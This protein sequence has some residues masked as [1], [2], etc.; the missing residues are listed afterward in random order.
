MSQQ[1]LKKELLPRH[2][3]MMALGGMIGTGIFKGSADTIS[4][5]GPGIVI[6][7]LLGG[8]LLYFVMG[9]LAEMASAYPN[10][11]IRALLHKAFGA[12]ASFVIG[13]LYWIQWILVMSVEVVAAGLFLQF[14]LQDVPLWTLSLV[15]AFCL[16]L[17]N[18]IGVKYYGELEFW[19]AGIKIVALSLFIVLG[20]ILLFGSPDQ[21]AAN[22]TSHGGFLPKGW[23][24]IIAS[25]L[26]V[27]FSYGGAELIGI[28]T[29][30]TKDADRVM[31]KIVRGV[32]VRV[33]LFYVLPLL[34]IT[35]LMPWNSIGGETSP[36]VQVL[37]GFGLTSA[38]HVMNFVMLTAVISAAN[39][40]MYVTSRMLFS[41]AKDGQASRY[42]TRL[43][44]LGVPIFGLL[45]SSLSLFIGVLTAYLTPSNVFHYLMGIPG[46]VTLVMWCSI[47]L[48]QIKL[49]PSYPAR[50]LY[51]TSLFPYA[52]IAVALVLTAILAVIM[53][54]KANLISTLVCLVVLA[55]LVASSRRVN[56]SEGEK[57]TV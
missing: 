42:F 21:A 29:A 41:L 36:F 47:C 4:L 1:Q 46:F 25:L 14:W 43:S 35:G 37:S 40:G 51:K 2:I 24:G 15:V 38:A 17:I 11:D 39:S 53:T 5:A 12:R 10:L 8:V 44:S 16:I 22:Y 13:W 7:Y 9:A 55:F 49:R 32:I 20:G 30:E 6:S 31:P 18:V 34:I 26:V 56:R 19:L 50:P 23:S 52:T 27:M 33:V 3:Q 45:V 54:D 28:T 48:A 57:M